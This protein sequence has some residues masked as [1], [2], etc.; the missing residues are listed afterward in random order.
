[1]KVGTVKRNTEKGMGPHALMPVLGRQ[2]QTISW[3][4]EASQ[5][6]TMSPASEATQSCRVPHPDCA[7]RNGTV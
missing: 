2:R 6:Y 7:S 1:M 3:D 4:V 5:D